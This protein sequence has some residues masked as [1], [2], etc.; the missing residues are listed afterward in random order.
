MNRHRLF[1]VLGCG[2]LVL[3][4]ACQAADKPLNAAMAQPVEEIQGVRLASGAADAAPLWAYCSPSQENTH[5]RT[6]HC[7]A[8]VWQ[9]L[10]I[11]HRFL[12]TDAALL[13]G[14]GTDLVWEL[15]IDDH[16]IDL[17]SF[18]TYDY[19]LPAMPASPSPIREVFA[20]VTD[21]DLV[22][23]NLNPG[24]H[25]LH[26]RAQDGVDQYHW[27]VNLVIEGEEGVDM[28]AAPFALHS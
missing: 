25:T 26:F 17:D 8:P 18:G 13:N 4:A 1:N 11:G 5:I 14:R 12:L 24:E 3:L 7:R 15:A 28:S 9:T 6:F 10:A 20:K 23:T 16:V 27:L 2:L 21:W 19:V 22:I